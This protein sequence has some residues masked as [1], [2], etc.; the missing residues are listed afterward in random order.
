MKPGKSFLV[1]ILILVFCFLISGCT[2]DLSGYIPTFSSSS[3]DKIVEANNRFSMDLYS[4]L[5]R[6]T[7]NKD[8]NL[9]FAPWSISSA[10]AIVYDGS[11]NKTADEIQNV[12]HFPENHTEL[13]EGFFSLDSE[14]TPNTSAYT[15]RTANALW[16]EKTYPFLPEF[17]QMASDSYGAQATN[18]NLINDAEGSRNTI[19]SWIAKETDGKI[20]GLVPQGSIDRYTRLIITNAIYFKGT[21]VKEFDAAKTSEQ[22]FQLT[23]G[24]TV[25]VEMMVRN[26]RSALFMYGESDQIQILEMPYVTGTGTTISMLIL[27]PREGNLDRLEKSLTVQKLDE[28]KKTMT[29]QM[30]LTYIPKFRLNTQYQL[31]RDLAAMGMPTAFSDDADLSGM[32]GTQNLAVD[33]IIHNAYL[34]VD[35]KGTEAAG[36]TYAKI[37]YKGDRQDP[38][39]FVFRADHPFILIIE[40]KD[41]GNILFMGRVMNPA[42]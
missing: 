27:L 41:N 4:D 22:P 30:V 29:T 7:A 36:A 8:R 26:D 33:E 39:P 34:D 2:Q 23:S 14:Y 35:E 13:R 16:A 20:N 5:A 12:F 6:N 1:M 17:M 9:F 18:L 42:E 3:R 31:S 24:E 38:D 19:N 37:Y 25:P 15:L 28:L 21:W 11:R 40:D 32:D 10:I